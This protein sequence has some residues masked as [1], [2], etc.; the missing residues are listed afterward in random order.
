MLFFLWIGIRFILF[1]GSVFFF[2]CI[3]F[4]DRFVWLKLLI[5]IFLWIV[6]YKLNILGWLWRGN[7]VFFFII[8]ILMF[9][10]LFL[11]SFMYV[12]G[13]WL[14][15]VGFLWKIDGLKLILIVLIWFSWDLR[16]D[17]EFKLNK[18]FLDNFENVECVSVNVFCIGNDIFI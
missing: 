5:F 2:F 4:L 3:L 18:I 15:D 17:N 6:L 12:I 10:I 16:G 1:E 7:L 11:Y 8:N 9:I 13:V 14:K